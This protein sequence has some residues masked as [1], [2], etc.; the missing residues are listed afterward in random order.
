M[1][2]DPHMEGELSLFFCLVDRT[3]LLSE[4]RVN[5]STLTI[6]FSITIRIHLSC[7]IRTRMVLSTPWSSDK[8][9][10]QPAI[11]S[12]TIFSRSLY[13]VMDTMALS[14]STISSDAP[15]SYAA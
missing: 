1:D 6:G 8:H 7:M 11:R 15:S 14:T 3:K 13:Y 4:R 10:I 9:F 2:H 5:L 12:T